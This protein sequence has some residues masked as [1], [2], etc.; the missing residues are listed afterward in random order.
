MKCNHGAELLPNIEEIKNKPESV[1]PVDWA[2]RVADTAR[3]NN[4][5]KSVTCRDGMN[6]LWTIINDIT[7]DKGQGE[8]LELIKDICEALMLSDGCDIA[9]NA[10]ALINESV[11]AYY[12]E[13]NAHIKRHRCSACVCE[14]LAANMPAAPV[15][16]EGET[17]TRRR[18]KKSE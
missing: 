8:D 11:T 13:W 10:A 18:R 12:E 6:Q 4:C 9:Q 15:R 2:K 16:A 7:I 14:A 3:M 1:C 5:G 17:G